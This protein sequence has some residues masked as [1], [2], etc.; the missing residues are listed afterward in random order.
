MTGNSV[1][2]QIGV[3]TENQSLSHIR[4]AAGQ[5]D[6]YNDQTDTFGFYN[7]AGTP[8]SVV[9]ANTGSLCADTS[10]GNYYQKT[11]DATNTGWVQLQ[12]LTQS[13]FV[14]LSSQT[15]SGAASVP[16]TSLITSMYATY[17]LIS[18][19]V[20][21]STTAQPTIQISTNNGSSWISTGY[22]SGITI[23]AYNAT[24][25]TNGTYTTYTP[26]MNNLLSSD[27]GNSTIFM[28]NLT[29][30]SNY[31]ANG[32]GSQINSGTLQNLIMTSTNATTNVNAIRIIGT[33]GTISGTFALYG[34]T[35]S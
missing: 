9:T 23:N 24:T 6:N 34:L 2:N 5:W 25:W 35:G 14:L 17:M 31:Y 32:T 16:F 21:V 30:G 8:E 15:V 22:T 11:T 3:S 20:S 26:A 12:P 13:S 10:T 4:S 7:N 33:A 19:N 18:S 29:N 28:Y 27:T 1:N